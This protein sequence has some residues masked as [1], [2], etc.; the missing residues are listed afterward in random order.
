MAAGDITISNLDLAAEAARPATVL[1]ADVS[2]STKLYE[3]AGDAIAQAAI[4]KCIEAMKRA[5]EATGGRV[6]KAIGDEEMGVFRMPD[7]AAAGAA[8]MQ[9]TVDPM[10]TLAGTNL[11]LRIAFRGGPSVQERDQRLR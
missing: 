4:G 9:G 11:Q 2:E 6:A 5:A 7:A 10:P 1:F 3:T 8:A